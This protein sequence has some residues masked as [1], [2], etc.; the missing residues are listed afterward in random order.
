MYLTPQTA[1]L[2][3]EIRK[4]GGAGTFDFECLY[5]EKEGNQTDI[6]R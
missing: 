4:N 2:T 3:I 1:S 6:T 5:L